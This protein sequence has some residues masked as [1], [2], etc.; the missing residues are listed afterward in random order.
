MNV[1]IRDRRFYNV[2]GEDS[3]VEEVVGGFDFTEGA[4]WHPVEKYL[5]FSDVPGNIM[6]KWTAGG[7]I[8][9]FR[10][11]S[12][13]A[14]GNCYD[15]QERLLTC[16]HATSR[17]TRT[18]LDG[19]VVVLAS[20][21]E[22]KELNSPNDIIVAN[23]GTIYFTDPSFGRMEYYGVPRPQELNWRGVYKLDSDGDNLTLLA[24]DFDQPN[25]LTLSLDE[26]LLFI[27]DTTKAHI[28]VYD[29][30]DDGTIF[31]NREWVKVCGDRDGVV[32]GMKIDSEEN[33]Y[34]AG[35]GGIQVFAADAI[36]LGVIYVP[37]V[38]TNFTWGDECL[39]TLYI[40]AGSSLYRTDVKVPGRKLF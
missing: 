39:K 11:P 33:L 29:V 2:V 15:K 18:E 1:E 30:R 13:M 32:D 23:D 3:A 27:N 10:E 22:G 14:N 24:D 8:E 12:N 25:G 38:V 26:K 20:H 31:N 28:R 7:G 21:Y 4:L 5:I 40:N 37:Q 17:V 19:S 34:V 35:P 16:E 6:R 9:T 36:C